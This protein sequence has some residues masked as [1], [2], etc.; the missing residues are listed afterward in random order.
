MRQPTKTAL[1]QRQPTGIIH[2]AHWLPHWLIPFLPS[3]FTGTYFL[4]IFLFLCLSF[5]SLSEF[6][7]LGCG[8][9]ALRVQSDGVTAWHCVVYSP[10][11]STMPDLCVVVSWPQRSYTISIRRIGTDIGCAACRRVEK[12]LNVK[13]TEALRVYIE[14]SR[15]FSTCTITGDQS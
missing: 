9:C 6:R 2:T 13:N 10:R 5:F 4:W 15:Q 11:C 3:D 14:G 12:R 7:L 8:C 1:L